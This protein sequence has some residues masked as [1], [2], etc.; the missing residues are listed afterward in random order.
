MY[1][2]LLEQLKDYIDSVLIY[3]CDTIHNH[4]DLYHKKN[5]VYTKEEVDKIIDEKINI[6]TK[7]IKKIEIEKYIP[8]KTS[9]EEEFKKCNL[10]FKNIFNKIH[11]MQLNSKEMSNYNNEIILDLNQIEQIKR[12]LEGLKLTY[13]NLE[14][15]IKKYSDRISKIENVNKILEVR[16]K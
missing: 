8:V 14:E 11:K 5:L 16:I 15:E 9:I 3:K 2:F 12:D 7:E 1:D 4:D 10:N 13:L 6:I